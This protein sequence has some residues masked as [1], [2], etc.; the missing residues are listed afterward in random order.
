MFLR[1][2]LWSVIHL[3]K[4]SVKSLIHCWCVFIF[5]INIQWLSLLSSSL[6]RLETVCGG[7]VWFACTKD[8][9]Q[10]QQMFW[11]IQTSWTTSKP[12]WSSNRSTSGLYGYL[13]DVIS[14][15]M[16][17]DC[18]YLALIYIYIY[19]CIRGKKGRF[20]SLGHIAN[21]WCTQILNTNNNRL[22]II[23]ADGNARWEL[24][25]LC[26][27]EEQNLAHTFKICSSCANLNTWHYGKWMKLYTI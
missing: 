1:G 11:C 7:G 26:L 5:G 14:N 27:I 6:S 3:I 9:E 17:V 25:V 23:R 19:I 18:V 4:N 21:N 15:I 8:E 12:D 10:Q 2:H 24:Y 22:I 13:V 20:L 16:V